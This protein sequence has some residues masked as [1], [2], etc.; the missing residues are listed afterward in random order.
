MRNALIAAAVS[1][2]LIGLSYANEARAAIRKPTNIPAQNLPVALQMLSREHDVQFIFR[3]DVV[4]TVQTPEV[5]GNLTTD[6]VLARLLSGTQLTYKYLDEKTVTIVP[7]SQGPQSTW[8]P[9]QVLGLQSQEAVAQTSD[10][11]VQVS[12]PAGD[13]AAA[14]AELGDQCG[15]QIRYEPLLAQGVKVAAVSGMLTVGEALTQLLVQTGLEADRVDDKTVVLRRADLHKGPAKKVID[16]RSK[17]DPGVEAGLQEVVV[18]AQK[19]VETLLDVPVPVSVITA[20]SLI[21]SGPLRIQDY[22]NQIPGLNMTPA[23]QDQNTLSI[24]GI[25]T[26]QGSN[27]TVGVVVDDVPI[28]A[29]INY[30]GGAVIPDLDPNDLKQIEVLRGPQGTLYGASSMGGLIKFVTVDPSPDA[31]AGRVQAGTSTVYNGAQLGYNFRGS[32][33]VPL[34]DTMAMR[35]SAFTRQEPGYIDNPYRGIDGVNEAHVRGGQVSV[36]WQ[37]SSAFSIKLNALCQDYRA[38]GSSEVDLPNAGPPPTLGLSGLQQNYGPGV[39]LSD[40]KLQF[41]SAIVKAKLGAI[42][43]TAI[44]AYNINHAQDTIEQGYAYA[45]QTEQYF[46]TPDSLT[47]ANWATRRFSEEL[48]LSSSIGEKFDWLAGL[49]YTYETAAG[50]YQNT[51]AYSYSSGQILGLLW[52]IPFPSTFTEYAAFADLTYHFTD[53]FDIQI[54]GRESA[55]RQT[56]QEAFYGPFNIPFFNVSGPVVEPNLHSRDSSFTYLFTPRLKL[57]PNMML[58]ARLASGYRPGG[59]NLNGVT[60]SYAPDKTYN[61]EIGLK[62]DF[63]DHSLSVDASAY[64]IDWKK[65][66]I[67]LIQPTTLLAYLANGSGAKS[68]G[69]ELSVTSIP[70]PGLKVA[71]WVALNNAVL[72]QDFPASSP[73]VETAGTRLPEAAKFTA[74]LSVDQEFPVTDNVT[75]SLGA[76]LIYVGDRWGVFN[77]PRYYYPSYAQLNLRGGL[78]RGSWA[79]DLYAYNVADK[80]DVLSSGIENSVPYAVTYIQPRTVGLSVSKSFYH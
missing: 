47:F 21:A 9:S 50:L 48:H 20:Q 57:S 56:L 14:L 29:D 53:R 59:P 34:S 12:L 60:S 31:F 64:Y 40:R 11:P 13:L 15:V 28:G 3:L 75:A 8:V 19:R 17:L 46:P 22:A 51:E 5:T 71:G 2:S 36:L 68:E 37:P 25:T 7:A 41:Y 38:D 45:Q 63:L 39:G 33:N 30:A 10:K 66:Q 49:F 77:N 26:G 79:V 72:T 32:M 58:Y 62:G 80:R 78:K 4:G 42:D 52:G 73:I 18:T 44:T 1:L 43:L 24:R 67:Q 55:N 27:R 76:T 16:E 70:L 69:L 6:E 74:N 23:L 65:I 61:Y 54:G 35:V